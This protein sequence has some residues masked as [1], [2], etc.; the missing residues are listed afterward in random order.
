MADAIRVLQFADIIN[1][2]DFID[3]I[4]QHAD[5]S[6]FS[7]SVCVRSEQS[8]IASPVFPEGIQHHKLNSTS[9]RDILRVAWQLGRLMRDWNINILHTHHYDAAIVGWLATRFYSPARLV[10]GRH[11]SDSIHRLPSVPKRR[12]LLQLE[13]LVNR[14]AERIIVPS[15]FIYQLLVR[16]QGIDP[17]KVDVVHY[18]FDSAK[19]TA[20]PSDEVRHFRKEFGLD[21]RVSIGCFGRLDDQKGHRF[22]LE[23]MALMKSRPI[24]LRLLI[25]G[26][27]PER[28]EFEKQAKAANLDEVVKFLGW[29]RDAMALMEA[30]DIVVQPTLQEAFSQVMVEAFYKRKPLVITRVSG[31]VDVIRDGVNGLLVPQQDATAIARAIER[32]ADDSELRSRMGEAAY[33]FAS[34]HLVIDKIIRK[35]EQSYLLAMGPIVRPSDSLTARQPR[36]N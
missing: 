15:Q 9:R 12:V 18:G 36:D 25:V 5:R 13:Q 14:A 23:A 24:R 33:D 26:E 2:Y 22:L 6:R 19:Y 17:G 28:A 8:N 27:G 4:I 35:Y 29:R 20:C 21:G 10:V 31:A 7:M 30:V 16:R 32:L 1:R 11:Y 34:K 3:N